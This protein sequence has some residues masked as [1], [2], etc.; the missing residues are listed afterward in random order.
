MLLLHNLAISIPNGPVSYRDRCEVTIRSV[1]V[2][3]RTMINTISTSLR[4]RIIYR[5]VAI[6]QVHVSR[7][8]QVFW[9]GHCSITTCANTTASRSWHT[10]R[11]KRAGGL[12]I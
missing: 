2:L 12:A 8:R 5:V 3:E 7:E 4:G 10:A 6:V 11:Y 9:I 1:T